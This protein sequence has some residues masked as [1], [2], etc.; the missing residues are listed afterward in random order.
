MN[1]DSIAAD[2]PEFFG[3]VMPGTKYWPEVHAVF[4]KYIESSC[5]YLNENNVLAKYVAIYS[6]LLSDRALDGILR[7]YES[8][9]GSDYITAVTGGQELMQKYYAESA[10]PVMKEALKKYTEELGAIVEKNRAEQANRY[11][12]LR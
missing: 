6:D 10:S 9:A 11:K 7:F 3:D 4:Q 2:N 8:E 1:P 5:N 12:N